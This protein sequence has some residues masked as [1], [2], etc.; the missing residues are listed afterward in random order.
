M[1]RVAGRNLAM[2]WIAGVFCT[3]VILVLLWFSLPMLPL[4]AEFAG[5]A[6]RNTLP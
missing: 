6:L 5:A 1:A 4:L 3:G 2:S